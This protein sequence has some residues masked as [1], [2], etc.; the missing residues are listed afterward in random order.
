MTELHN[1]DANLGTRE[2]DWPE[3]DVDSD[4]EEGG[5]AIRRAEAA[6][7]ATIERSIRQRHA[8][9][10]HDTIPPALYVKAQNHQDQLT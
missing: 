8:Q 2:E 6:L 7:H 5:E 10:G 1:M 4:T 9:S 3:V